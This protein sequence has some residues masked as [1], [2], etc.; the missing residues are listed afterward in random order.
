MGR[1]SL[2]RRPD[3]RLRD[4]APAGVPAAPLVARGRARLLAPL[5]RRALLRELV[6]GRGASRGRGRAPLR[7][8]VADRSRPAG[9]AEAGALEPRRGD[10]CRRPDA[11]PA[12]GGPLRGAAGRRGAPRRTRPGEGRNARRT[13][14]PRP[15]SGRRDR[16]RGRRLAP[17]LQPSRDGRRVHSALPPEPPPVLRRAPLRLAAR[18]PRSRLSERNDAALLHGLAGEREVDPAGRHGEPARLARDLAPGFQDRLGRGGGGG[19]ASR[20]SA[21]GRAPGLLR[22]DVSGARLPPDGPPLPLPRAGARSPRAPDPDGPARA[23]RGPVGRP[24]A[25]SVPAGRRRRGRG[26]WPPAEHGAHAPRES[27]SAPGRLSRAAYGSR[28]NARR[29]A[30]TAC[31]SSSATARCTT[32]T[33]E[34]VYNG[35]D[36]EGSRVLF[37]HDLSPEKNERLLAHDPS[38]TAWLFLPE[39]QDALVPYPR[40]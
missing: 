38:R 33:H 12:V 9:A 20:P 17:R 11:D 7:R 19:A 27:Y 16:P 37:A 26:G 13:A 35:A 4:V 15:P 29:D 14:R 34:W 2:R 25:R 22:R 31:S 23:R 6:L 24:E 30:R 40:R 32:S 8:R 28:R 21:Q 10:G 3:V 36:L 18:A 39:E 1:G 5:R